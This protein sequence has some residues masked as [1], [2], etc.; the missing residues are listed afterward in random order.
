M[1]TRLASSAPVIL[2]LTT[3]AFASAFSK[4]DL[5]EVA[6]VGGKRLLLNGVGT[7]QA[8]IF[9]VDVYVAGLY[10]EASSHDPQA[11]LASPGLKK[12]EMH[13]VHDVPAAKLSDA[14]EESRGKNCSSEC[15]ALK[16]PFGR[17]GSLMTDMKSG[18]RLTFVFRPQ[19]VEVSVKDG[20]PVMIEAPGFSR[21]LLAT[22]LGAQPPN[23]SLKAG[24]LGHSGG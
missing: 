24:M 19:G 1:K 14:W 4:A 13:F 18:D 7:R 6:S 15:D 10:L 22:W 11:I 23:E 17:L 5:P 8:T 2:F 16:A 20:A 3:L 12:I 9:K 21:T